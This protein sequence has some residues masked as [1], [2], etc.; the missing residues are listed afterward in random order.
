M[1]SKRGRL[2]GKSDSQ[3]GSR[4]AAI[5]T[6]EVL[7]DLETSET[8]VDHE[9]SKTMK[10]K[11][12]MGSGTTY[13]Q[14]RRSQRLSERKTESSPDVVKQTR[15][16]HRSRAREP[17]G[18]NDE[19]R[20]EVEKIINHVAYRVGVVLESLL[21]LVNWLCMYFWFRAWLY[22]T[23]SSGWAIVNQRILQ[24]PHRCC[25]GDKYV[26]FFRSTSY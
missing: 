12:K 14:R 23:E 25:T 26:I 13:Q 10:G 24:N 17:S 11:G 4:Q 21:S 2:R 22:H 9:S 18:D 1:T 20:Y 8:T 16:Q 19:T 3:S 5:D 7:D 15:R 6:T